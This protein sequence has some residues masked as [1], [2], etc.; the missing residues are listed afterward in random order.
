[1]PKNTLRTGIGGALTIALVAGGLVA[2]TTVVSAVADGS[3]PSPSTS[4]SSDPSAGPSAPGSPDA[5][6]DPSNGPS[7]AVPTSPSPSLVPR[8]VPAPAVPVVPPASTASGPPTRPAP[9]GYRVVRGY[10]TPADGTLFNY[11]YSKKRY[12]NTIRTHVLK[13]IKAVPSGGKIRIAVYSINDNT[14]VDELIRAKKRG[15]SVQVIVNSHNLQPTRTLKSSPSFKRLRRALGS[16]TTRAGW[17]P[18]NVSF[19]KI[20]KKSCRG[21]GGNVHYKMFLFSSAGGGSGTAKPWIT[22]M[23]SPNLTSLAANGQWNHLTTY[24]SPST[25]DRYLLMFNEM[26]QDRDFGATQYRDY[27]DITPQTWFFPRPG[28]TASTD[29]LMKDLNQVRCTGLTAGYGKAGRTFIR[30]GAYVWYDTR[31]QWLAKKVRSLWNAGCD[32]AVEYAI[33]GNTVK[34]ILYSPS[35]RGRIPMRQVATY[36]KAGK[37]LTYDHAK[38]VTV[39]G[40]YGDSNGRSIT[41]AGT[42][43]FSNLGFYSDDTTQVWGDWAT[44]DRFRDNF[45]RVWRGPHSHVPSPTSHIPGVIEGR[46]VKLGQGK[47]ARLEAS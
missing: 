16:H 46:Y 23:G 6:T 8:T 14:T 29:P 38:Y 33:M 24:S 15:V 36:S 28:T 3:S 9:A 37:V 27:T 5:S 26:K 31:G 41:W 10:Y 19:A 7:Q 12:R 40:A 20:C 4:A 45:Y 2:G 25:Y 47:Y 22:M 17:N 44:Y 18:D 21:K 34:K 30:I 39:N 35:G 42:T 1:M 32:V 43:N 11:P 13:T